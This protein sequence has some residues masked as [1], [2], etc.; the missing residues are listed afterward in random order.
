MTYITQLVH[1][2]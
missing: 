2:Y 1:N